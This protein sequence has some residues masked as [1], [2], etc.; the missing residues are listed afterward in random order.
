MTEELESAERNPKQIRNTVLALVGIMLISGIF[1]T[2]AYR[3]TL[4]QQRLT[5]R[6]PFVGKLTDQFAAKNQDGKI[7][8]TG[9]LSEKVWLAASVSVKNPGPALASIEAMKR[10]AEA[11]QGNE[12]LRFVLISV[13]FENEDIA[14]LKAFADSQELDSERWWILKEEEAR[15]FISGR[16][17]LTAP[18]QADEEEMQAGYGEIWYDP[19]IVLVDREQHLRGYLNDLGAAVNYFNFEEIEG[20]E[21]KTAA[22][23]AKLA[24]TVVKLQETK[25]PKKPNT[26]SLFIGLAIFVTF[27]VVFIGKRRQGIT[28]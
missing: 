4:E 16:L 10:L 9:D 28:R 13:D 26:V 27:L 11:N 8:S 1:V 19:R 5:E 12:G 20:D 2:I 22:L 17:K 6:A 25:K 24:Q 3:N 18:H 15:K 7:V 14:D 23:D 21:A